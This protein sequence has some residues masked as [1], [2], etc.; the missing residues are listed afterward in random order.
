MLLVLASV[1]AVLAVGV[2][3]VLKIREESHRTACIKN[4]KMISVAK[5]KWAMD[6]KAKKGAK[7]PMDDLAGI[8][9]QGPAYGPMCPEGGAYEVNVIGVAPTCS[10]AKTDKH[11]L[12]ST[13]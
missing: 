5:D 10:L 1:G 11:I 12:A 13:P 4:L 9:L 6:H 7:V 3:N 2:P 8:Y